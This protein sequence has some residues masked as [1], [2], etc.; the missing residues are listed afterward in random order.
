MEAAV[1]EN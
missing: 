1:W